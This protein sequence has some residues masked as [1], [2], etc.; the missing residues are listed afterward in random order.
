MQNDHS[1]AMPE[2]S[3]NT[4][5]LTHARRRKGRPPKG[6]GATMR[7]PRTKRAQMLS[8]D[9][10]ERMRRRALYF[11][12]LKDQSRNV[13]RTNRDIAT[14]ASAHYYPHIS[15]ST[16][17]R[18]SDPRYMVNN[19]GV[20]HLVIDAILRE[21]GG[22]HASLEQ[23]MRDP[24]VLLADGSA[25]ALVRDEIEQEIVDIFRALPQ[26]GQQYLLDSARRERHRFAEIGEFASY[27]KALYETLQRHEHPNNGTEVKD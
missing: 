25:N 8:E 5:E 27:R 22:S 14:D 24:D 17:Q 18:I 16:V 2:R 13:H 11:R 9:E 26:M 4:D 7:A 23:V 15:E 20:S 19:V 21:L 1:G 3:G 12:W 10:I 6:E